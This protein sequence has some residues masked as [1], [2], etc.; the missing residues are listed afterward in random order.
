[1]TPINNFC[2]TCYKLDKNNVK[3]AN[4]GTIFNQR[5]C[6]YLCIKH[7]KVLGLSQSPS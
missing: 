4:R 7:A 3:V 1:M 2:L 5:T 6:H